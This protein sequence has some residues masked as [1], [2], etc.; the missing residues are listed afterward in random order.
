MLTIP[1]DM[2]YFKTVQANINNKFPPGSNLKMHKI[3]Q[4]SALI[5]WEQKFKDRLVSPNGLTE[6]T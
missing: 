2:L 5:K 6:M 4:L 3:E 1:Q